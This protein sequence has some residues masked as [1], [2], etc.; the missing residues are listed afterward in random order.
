M[1]GPQVNVSSNYPPDA[2]VITSS[3]WYCIS[4]PLTMLG[5]AKKI[6]R[7]K[8]SKKS[9]TISVGWPGE[10]NEILWMPTMGPHELAEICDNRLNIA[11]STLCN[12]VDLI[13]TP[14]LDT[15]DHRYCFPKEKPQRIVMG[16][17]GQDFVGFESI[18][19]RSECDC[20][21]GDKTRCKC[22]SAQM[23]TIKMLTL[24]ISRSIASVWEAIEASIYRWLREQENRW[25][26]KQGTS[27]AAQ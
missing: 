10:G 25:L 19:F 20:G 8:S 21:Q 27:A 7:K 2:Q 22:K 13:F 6:F 11:L 4:L 24:P 1:D 23:N 26:Q 16:R 17:M 15:G 18:E 5:S 12:P 9:I 14:Y 3:I